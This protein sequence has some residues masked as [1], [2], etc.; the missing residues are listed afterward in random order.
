MDNI[1]KAKINLFAV[2][3]NLQELCEMD[4][5]AKNLIKDVDLAVQFSVPEVGAAVLSFKG[6]KCTFT[7]GKGRSALKLWFADA[8]HFN[9]MIGGGKTIPIFVN[10]FKV[11]FLLDTFMKLAD[12]LSFYLQPNAEQLKVINND[13][14]KFRTATVLTAYTAFFAMSEI[15]NSDAIGKL[16][17]SR[18]PVGVIQAS[19]YD[20]TGDV[21]ISIDVN[22]NHVMTSSIGQ[23]GI[24]R[25]YMTFY[26]IAATND[27]L[28]GVT[29]TFTAI[30]MG[31]L[32]LSGYTPM[33]ENMSK[34]LNQVSRYLA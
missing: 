25:S 7:R 9:K 16:N 18:I 31:K 28:T 10:V 11:G 30:G 27:V 1:T 2:L 32:A 3:R 15:G 8:E 24:G 33:L 19:I 26:S 17:A 6:G 4:E 14:K 29:D 23:N 21:H 5:D 20:E 13:P 34:L 12:I 22:D